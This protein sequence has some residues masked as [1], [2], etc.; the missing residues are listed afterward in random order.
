M[1]RRRRRCCRPSRRRS[2][3]RYCATCHSDRGKAGGLSLAAF[4]AAKIEEN[5]ELTE[6]MIRKLRAGMMPPAGARRP[7]PAVI[8]AMVT[9]FE[10]RM[11]KLRGAQSESRARVRSSASTAPSTRTRCAIC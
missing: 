9:S 7:E 1:R 6:K 11:D 10:S 3:S 5:G 4:D 2:S 8:K